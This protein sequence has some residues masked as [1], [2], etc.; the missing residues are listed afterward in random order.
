MTSRSFE[1]VEAEIK[2]VIE[3]RIQPVVEEDGGMILYHGFNNGIVS[4]SMLG[5][6]SGCPS[7]EMTLKHGIE[8]MLRHFVPEVEEVVAV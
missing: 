8:N 7:S 2:K 3:E 1:E 6:C 5:A 4:V